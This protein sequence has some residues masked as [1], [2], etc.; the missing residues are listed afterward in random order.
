MELLIDILATPVF[1]LEGFSFKRISG[2]VIAWPEKGQINAHSSLIPI[3]MAF[4]IFIFH[5][6]D[7]MNKKFGVLRF[8][9]VVFK[10]IGVVMGVIAV[11]GSIG[12]CIVTA[13]SGG[14]AQS[15]YNDFG[16]YGN[17]GAGGIFGGLL[18]GLMILLSFGIAALSEY[19]VGEGIFLFLAIE[20]NTRA[21]AAYL[22]RQVGNNEA[23]QA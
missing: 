20:E 22:S 13:V 8:I 11:A 9:G 16:Y 19:A 15:L 21:T 18:A 6:E 10:V 12:V 1:Y 3:G 2:F 7:N 4:Y 14:A 23:P 17:V 5:K